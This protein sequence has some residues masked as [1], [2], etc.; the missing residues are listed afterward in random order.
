VLQKR[1]QAQQS[2][3][4]AGSLR[5][6]VEK[7]AITWKLALFLLSW[8]GTG[9]NCVYQASYLK[10]MQDEVLITLQPCSCL[11]KVAKV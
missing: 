4:S 6:S 5:N 1:L 2:P 3:A 11:L 10:E 8:N 9:G 7:K